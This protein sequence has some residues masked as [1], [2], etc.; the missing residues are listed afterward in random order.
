MP[1]PTHRRPGI[2]Y[3]AMLKSLERE[4]DAPSL[5]TNDLLRELIDEV[6]GMRRDL[7][8]IEWRRGVALLHGLDPSSK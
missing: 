1:A 5:I 4:G 6:R 2:D 7:K 3:D 8:A